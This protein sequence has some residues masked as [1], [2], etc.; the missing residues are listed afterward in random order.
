MA[1]GCSTAATCLPKS[2]EHKKPNLPTMLAAK[3]GESSSFSSTACKREHK[4]ASREG[5]AVMRNFFSEVRLAVLKR[6]PRI[7]QTS[8]G[9]WDLS[10]SNVNPKVLKASRVTNIPEVSVEDGSIA[11]K[12]SKK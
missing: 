7:A 1:Q 9:G 11:K 8:A 5:L 6:T 12:S 3:D 4:L 2:V 10:G